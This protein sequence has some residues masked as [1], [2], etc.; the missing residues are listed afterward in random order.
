MKLIKSMLT[1]AIITIISISYSGCEKALTDSCE[2]QDMNEVLDCGSEK[3]VEVCCTAGL[4]C[5]YKYNGQEYPD[6]NAGLSSLADALGCNYK[7]SIEK[8]K[9]KKLIIKHLIALK[10]KACN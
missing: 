1:I 10:K 3:N 6:T 4:A 7:S 2:Q 8:E 5:V 9:Q